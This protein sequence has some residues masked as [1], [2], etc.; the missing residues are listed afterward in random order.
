MEG[1]YNSTHV[2]LCL[3]LHTCLY[4]YILFS[5]DPPPPPHIIDGLVF[6]SFY[7]VQGE[8]STA[9][10]S[11]DADDAAGGAAT[12]DVDDDDMVGLEA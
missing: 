9:A 1:R 2:V 12:T 3:T 11:A 8:L 10:A 5:I 6:S 7:R 4:I